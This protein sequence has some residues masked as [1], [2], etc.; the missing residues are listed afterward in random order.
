MDHQRQAGFRADHL[1]R[2]GILQAQYQDVRW[3]E[4]ADMAVAEVDELEQSLGAV[5]ARGLDGDPGRGGVDAQLV[6]HEDRGGASHVGAELE[7]EQAVDGHG[8]GGVQGGVVALDGEP[9]LR[10]DV[11]RTVHDDLVV[12]V[13]DVRRVQRS[14]PVGVAGAAAAGGAVDVDDDDDDAEAEAATA[15]VASPK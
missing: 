15:G 12:L 8:G 1:G 13:D 10:S 11:R 6:V 5:V 2:Q 3:V 9:A 14:Q 4:F 7:V